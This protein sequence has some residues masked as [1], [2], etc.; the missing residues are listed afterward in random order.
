MAKRLASP[1]LHRVTLEVTIAASSRERNIE[2]AGALNCRAD[3]DVSG[4][5][6]HVRNPEAKIAFTVINR[7]SATLNGSLIFFRD[8]AIAWLRAEA[9]L[10]P[11][12]ELLSTSCNQKKCQPAARTFISRA[13]A[14]VS[15]IDIQFSMNFSWLR[16]NPLG[17]TLPSRRNIEC[18][19][20][21][22][23]FQ[24]QLELLV[25]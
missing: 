4:D 20:T 14:A 9:S 2:E 3:L 24:F 11:A 12:A 5:K 15:R 8:R 16:S 21:P 1:R 10:R 17:R 18:G 23:T 7:S 25:A 19:F 22:S 6:H 13:K